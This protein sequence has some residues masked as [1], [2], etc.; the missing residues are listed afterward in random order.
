[1]VRRVNLATKKV[2]TVVEMTMLYLHGVAFINNN[3][4]FSSMAEVR[5]I[6]LKT[7]RT[8]QSGTSGS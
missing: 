8:N 6:E 2:E 4:Y 3:I 1:M 7:D 5:A